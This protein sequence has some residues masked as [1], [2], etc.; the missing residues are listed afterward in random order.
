MPKQKQEIDLSLQ[1]YKQKITV[2]AFE[3]RKSSID[4]VI[5]GLD[6]NKAEKQQFVKVEVNF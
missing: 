2:L 3:Y 1:E 4:R 5:Q 6:K